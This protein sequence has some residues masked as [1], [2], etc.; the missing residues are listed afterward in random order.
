MGGGTV[1]LIANSFPYSY[2]LGAIPGQF[3]NNSGSPT[4]ITASQWWIYSTE[5]AQNS[6]NGMTAPNKHYTQ[7]YTGATPAYASAGNW[8]LYGIPP[9]LQ[10]SPNNLTVASGTSISS[11]SFTP[12]FAG[13]IDGDTPVTAGITGSAIFTPT[14][15]LPS[16]IYNVAYITGL[17][18]SL[19]YFFFDNT[20]STKELTVN[21]PVVPPV[22]VPVVAPPAA[23]PDVVPVPVVVS[24]VVPVAAPVVTPVT[25]TSVNPE[26][27]SSQIVPLQ[28]STTYHPFSTAIGISTNY[29]ASTPDSDI[30]VSDVS[31]DFSSNTADSSFSQFISQLGVVSNGFSS[32]TPGNAFSQSISKK[33]D[34][35]KPILPI[36]QIKNSAGRVKHL[37]L[38]ANKQFLSL[39]MEDGSVRI[40]DFERGV[41]RK[42]VT[43]NKEQALTDISAVD[44]KGES[45]SIASKAGI[46]VQDIISSVTDDKLAINEP[47]INHFVTA[48]DDSLLLI[49]VGTNKLS[50]WDTK[51]SKKRW[52]FDHERGVINNLA[53]SDDKRYGAVLS[54]QPNVYAMDKKNK[55]KPLTD[56]VDIIDLATG[57]VIKALANAGEDIVY[58]RFKDND[59]LLVGLASGKLLDWSYGSR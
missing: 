30:S 42:I 47:G 14:G 15:V 7:L 20:A 2:S 36:L 40:W 39:L 59:T 55:F 9:V 35:K 4:P 49:N 33:E 57:K 37:E 45:L 18:S 44:D 8:F 46:G 13:F 58:M 43:E 51:Q 1:T 22:V 25:P 5:P 10:V 48:N 23:A 19:G 56:A 16:G 12:N 24:D 29:S 54:R 32:N 52:S 34:N 41:Q 31:N 28:T 38:S 21:S 53:L 11:S 50:L 27:L 17:A 6:L 26:I 3:I